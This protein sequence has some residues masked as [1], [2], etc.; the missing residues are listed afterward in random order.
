[1]SE[2]ARVGREGRSSEVSGSWL[3]RWVI[4]SF[5]GVVEELQWK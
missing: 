1:M 3:L 2:K 4:A 5:N